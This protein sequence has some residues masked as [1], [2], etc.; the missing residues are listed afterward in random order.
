MGIPL[1]AP[2]IIK[3][4]YGV[5]LTYMDFLV[6]LDLIDLYGF[7]IF[8]E[9]LGF[10]EFCYVLVISVFHMWISISFD[11]IFYILCSPRRIPPRP[12]SPVMSLYSQAVSLEGGAR[13]SLSQVGGFFSLVLKPL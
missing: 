5:I 3:V 1:L 11:R 4:G 10:L 6:S 2:S 13:I 8:F 7:L 12:L 9:S